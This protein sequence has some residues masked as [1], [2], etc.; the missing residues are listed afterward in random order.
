[1]DDDGVN[2]DWVQVIFFARPY[3]QALINTAPD[4]P[5]GDFLVEGYRI[6]WTN[7]D[8]AGPIFPPTD[9]QTSIIIPSQEEGFGY[10]RLVNFTQK[11]LPWVTAL[12][13]NAAAPAARPVE[14]LTA[15]ISF[16]GRE[17]G[18]D[19]VQ[20]FVARLSVEVGD[21]ITSDCNLNDTQ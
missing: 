6:D 18:T 11:S 9:D 19:R 7:V 16:Y 2:E 1:V 5:H 14:H 4:F 12:R 13:Y 3:S 10:I 17:M 15:Q 8:P 21:V 20:E